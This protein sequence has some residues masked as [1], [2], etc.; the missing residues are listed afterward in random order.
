MYG[1]SLNEQDYSYYYA[2]FN[3]IDLTSNRTTKIRIILNFYIQ[4]MA[5]NHLKK[6]EMKQFNEFKYDVQI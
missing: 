5:K 3:R 4:N 6:S 1:H 2:L